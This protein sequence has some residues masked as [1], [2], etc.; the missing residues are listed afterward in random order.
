M[1]LGIRGPLHTDPTF[2]NSAMLKIED[3]YR[4]Q[5]RIHAW[6]FWNDL[7]PQNQAAMFSRSS[8]T[9]RYATRTAETGITL[10][11]RDHNSIA[12]RAPKEWASLPVKLRETKSF[13][14]F[15]E[16][17]KKQLLQQYRGFKCEQVGCGI[18]SGGEG[19]RAAL[20][21]GQEENT[22]ALSLL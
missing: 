3:L 1:I 15:K 22:G 7:L 20:Q 11:T 5:L 6:Q 4:Q 14:G 19:G 10:G 2:S 18:C 16:Q 17:S 12:Y 13:S 8:E 21:S 9:H